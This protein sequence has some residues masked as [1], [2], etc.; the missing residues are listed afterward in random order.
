MTRLPNTASFRDRSGTK[1]R[2][3][4]SNHQPIHCAMWDYLSSYTA[5]SH[6]T[7]IVCICAMEL[8]H[9]LPLRQKFPPLNTTN[10]RAWYFPLG[11]KWGEHRGE[12]ASP[13]LMWLK[14]EFV[15]ERRTKNS[16]LSYQNCTVVW[17][18]GIFKQIWTFLCL[19]CR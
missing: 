3:F 7:K 17:N 5:F 1:P 14:F 10:M 19:F 11:R 2:N 8:S 9:A 6:H 18:I 13:S 15:G 12:I 16:S 4:W